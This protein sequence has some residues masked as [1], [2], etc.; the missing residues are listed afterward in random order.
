[1]FKDQI[2]LSAS[3]TNCEKTL[4]SLVPSPDFAYLCSYKSGISVLKSLE[5]H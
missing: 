4:L 3:S 1:M 2:I 5:L